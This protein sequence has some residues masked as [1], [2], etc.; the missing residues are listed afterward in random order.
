MGD[1]QP[2]EFISDHPSHESRIVALQKWL[3]EA[4]M[5]SEQSDCHRTVDFLH[6]FGQSWGMKEKDDP[7][8][9]GRRGPYGD[10]VVGF[11]GSP[12]AG[13][14]LVRTDAA[15]KEAYKEFESGEG[16]RRK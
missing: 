9:G 2:P 16:R 15:V 6:A 5:R 11:D 12:T 1:K 14:T 7:F 10:R 13:E 8:A 4:R 3:P